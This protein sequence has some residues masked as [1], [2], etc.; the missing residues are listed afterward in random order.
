[1]ENGTIDTLQISDLIE[2]TLETP[3]NEDYI[4][5]RMNAEYRSDKANRKRMN[6]MFISG[7]PEL[8]HAV[9][10]IQRAWRKHLRLKNAALQTLL[11]ESD[12]P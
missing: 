3:R 8:M 2:S 11:I 6:H 12:L 10:K 4:D 7:R 1:M 9:V 5:S